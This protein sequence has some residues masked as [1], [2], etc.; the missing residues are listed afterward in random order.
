MS[1]AHA[2]GLSSTAEGVET[3][4]QLAELLTLGCEHAQG[5]LFAEP[6]LAEVLTDDPIGQLGHWARLADGS[7]G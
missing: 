4:E 6:R 1:L 2:L 7:T 3:P 5:N